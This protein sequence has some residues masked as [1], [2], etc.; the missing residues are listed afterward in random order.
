MVTETSV[1]LVLV[2]LVVPVLAEF[3][4]LGLAGLQ[5]LRSE[6]ETRIWCHPQNWIGRLTI[7]GCPAVVGLAAVPEVT[8]GC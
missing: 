3:D 2:G 5:V 7:E 6:Q 8:A 4:G 1:L